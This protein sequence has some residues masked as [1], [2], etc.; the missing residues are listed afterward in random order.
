MV[1]VRLHVVLE[2]SLHCRGWLAFF[3][4]NTTAAYRRLPIDGCLSSADGCL[5]S[6]DGCL[7]SA[8]GC[9]SSADT[10]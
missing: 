5:S 3:C 1:S 4:P 7:S 8:D 10:G 6:A 9:L 2:A